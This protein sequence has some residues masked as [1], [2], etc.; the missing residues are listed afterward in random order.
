MAQLAL[1]LGIVTNRVR[2]RR[3]GKCVSVLRL[4]A[5]KIPS[6]GSIP[7]VGFDLRAESRRVDCASGVEGRGK[8]R[9]Q[10]KGPG[11]LYRDTL[12][13]DLDIIRLHQSTPE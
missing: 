4:A 3:F 2:S 5:G 6:R 11:L 12:P 9:V 13:I 7:A 8:E 10:F 1:I